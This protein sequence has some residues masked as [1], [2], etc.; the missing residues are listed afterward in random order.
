MAEVLGKSLNSLLGPKLMLAK[1]DKHPAV[2]NFTKPVT[3]LNFGPST[4]HVGSH[5]S[6]MRTPLPKAPPLILPGF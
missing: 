4:W 5:I 3:N 2:T 1:C 6:D